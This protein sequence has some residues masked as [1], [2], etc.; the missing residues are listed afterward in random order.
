MV[1]DNGIPQMFCG[2]ISYIEKADSAKES[3]FLGNAYHGDSPDAFPTGS[4]GWVAD[5]LRVLLEP[6]RLFHCQSFPLF[7]GFG[8]LCFE[9]IGFGLKLLQLHIILIHF[10]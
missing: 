4:A 8:E 10:R 6:I 3:A 7:I 5:I 2:F 1:S 9:I